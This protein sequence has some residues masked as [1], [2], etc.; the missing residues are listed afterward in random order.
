MFTWNSNTHLLYDV[1]NLDWLSPGVCI[2]HIFTRASAYSTGRVIIFL[3]IARR[4]SKESRTNQ[5]P[6]AYLNLACF[7]EPRVPHS[8]TQLL[9]FWFQDIRLVE[10]IHEQFDGTKKAFKN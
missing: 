6:S 5:V 4:T 3:L 7:T 10:V 2:I 1:S 8:Q 9:V